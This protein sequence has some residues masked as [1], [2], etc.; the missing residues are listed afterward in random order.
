MIGGFRDDGFFLL[1]VEGC[2][3]VEGCQLGLR[4]EDPLLRFRMLGC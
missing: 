3:A 2:F 4:V 1:M